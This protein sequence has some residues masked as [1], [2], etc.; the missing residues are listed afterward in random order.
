LGPDPGPTHKPFD[1]VAPAALPVFSLTVPT[2]PL[3][4]SPW[5]NHREAEHHSLNILHCLVPLGSAHLLSSQMS[6]PGR[7]SAHLSRFNSSITLRKSAREKPIDSMKGSA[8]SHWCQ[9]LKTV[10]DL[11]KVGRI[12]LT[13]EDLSGA[14]VFG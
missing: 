5:S 1:D 9:I 3:H 7:A 12:L 8:T 11:N 13:S 6:S 4:F 14:S 2:S 10:M